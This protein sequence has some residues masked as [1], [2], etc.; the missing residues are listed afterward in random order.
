MYDGF[1]ILAHRYIESKQHMMFASS[2]PNIS[3]KKKVYYIV[4]ILASVVRI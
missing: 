1:Q 2:D 4:L 3:P